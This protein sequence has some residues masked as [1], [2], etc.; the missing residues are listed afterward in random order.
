MTEHKKCEERVNGKLKD[1]IEDL[2]KLWEAYCNGEE[3]VEDLGNIYEYG[4][5]FDY[6]PR[7]TFNDQ[8]EGYFR[9]QLSWGGPSDELRF[10]TGPDFYPHRIEYWFLD[11]FDGA[12]RILNGKD[13]SLL[14]EIFD[15]F[16][17]CGTV[18]AQFEK[19]MEE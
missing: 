17:E 18:E 13:G 10:F 7:G 2:Q 11:W 8:K 14:L 6:V 9:Y 4:L 16:K 12:N 3:D 19:A 1:R 5:S 15:W